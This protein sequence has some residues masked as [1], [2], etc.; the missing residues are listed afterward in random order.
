MRKYFFMI[1]ATFFAGNLWAAC[2]P[3]TTILQNVSG[4]YYN[5]YL[6]TSTAE[7]EARKAGGTGKA[8]LC[9]YEDRGGCPLDEK[10]AFKGAAVGNTDYT[11]LRVYTCAVEG[12]NY[13]WKAVPVDEKCY[14]DE[15]V[16]SESVGEKTLYKVGYKYCEQV[17]YLNDVISGIVDNAI[18]SNNDILLQ[19]FWNALKAEIGNVYV[20]QEFWDAVV[21]VVNS[22]HDPLSD[23][24]LDIIIGLINKGIQDSGFADQI[25]DIQVDINDIKNR[26]NKL[27][28]DVTELKDDLKN[29]TDS[30]LNLAVQHK[31]DVTEIQTEFKNVWADL[32]NKMTEEQV[33]KLVQEY[34]IDL[35]KKIMEKIKETNGKLDKFKKEVAEIEKDLRD[36]LEEHEIEIEALDERIKELEK[37]V[38]AIEDDVTQLKEDLEDTT[39]SLLNLAVQHNADVS[40]IRAEFE[41]VWERLDG[42]MSDEQIQEFVNVQI[43]ALEDELMLLICELGLDLDEFKEEVAKIEK[44]LNDRLDEIGIRL[45]GLE[46]RIEELEDAKEEIFS[47]LTVYAA[48]DEDLQQQIDALRADLEDKVTMEQVSTTVAE[49]LANANL[50][51]NQTKQVIEIIMQYTEKLSPGQRQEVKDMIEEKIGKKF[52]ELDATNQLQDAQRVSQANVNSAMSVLNAFAAGQD[53]SVWRNADG[54][55]NTARLASDATAGVILGT[56]GGLISNKV[57]KK[58]QVKKGFEGIGCYVGGQVVAD[59]G[60]EFTVGMM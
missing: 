15:L 19:Q 44:E 56:A 42:M 26:L 43:A 2:L 48:T 1:F 45:D 55:F 54:K 3:T 50:N 39:E 12:N 37:R 33:E 5:E 27:E 29:T 11:E 53:A 9:G 13:Y 51:E 58:N 59:Y 4:P 28:D 17:V 6:Y 49:M 20:S 57:I 10:F 35:E 46:S 18:N 7:R 47:L 24:D 21:N 31:V 60:D 40:E 30:L 14:S 22:M 8:Y 34:I 41:I 32:G 36:K 38:E 16:N 23:D 25:D 52:E